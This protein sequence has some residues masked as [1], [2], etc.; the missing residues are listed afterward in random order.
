MAKEVPPFSLS[1]RNTVL[2]PSF[3]LATAAVKITEKD[4]GAFGIDSFISVN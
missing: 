2:H 1:S 4:I 3:Y